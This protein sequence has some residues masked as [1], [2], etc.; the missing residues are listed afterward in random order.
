MPDNSKDSCG[1]ARSV[2]RDQT[3]FWGHSL[4]SGWMGKIQ[5]GPAIPAVE[6]AVHIR[7]G[8]D[9]QAVAVRTR[10]VVLGRVHLTRCRRQG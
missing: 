1:G 8:V 5:L 9:A 4:I 2:M 3:S 7:Q 10:P 6:T